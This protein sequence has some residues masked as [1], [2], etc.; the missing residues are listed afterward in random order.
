MGLNTTLIS[1]AIGE[2]LYRKHGFEEYDVISLDLSKYKGGEGK[3]T[4]KLLVMN[5]PPKVPKQ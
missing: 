1:S 5:R 2:S 4:A 3:S